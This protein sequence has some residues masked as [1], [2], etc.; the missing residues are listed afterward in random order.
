MRI[1]RRVALIVLLL[2]T[3]F[4]PIACET[5]SIPDKDPADLLPTVVT[6]NY[7]LRFF[8]ERLAGERVAIEWLVPDGVN[9][10]DWQPTAED[11]AKMN[12]ADL[13]LLN[14]AGYEGWLE[15]AS[16]SPGKLVDTSAG[17]KDR[18][19]E[20]DGR[21]HSHGP[22]GSH[23]HA[24][25][26]THTWL[27]PDLALLQ[28]K[29]VLN[30]LAELDPASQDAMQSNY[31]LLQ[32]DLLIRSAG[33]EQA[34]N[35]LPETAVVF[36]HPVYQY[37]QRRFRMNGRSV[38]FEPDQEPDLASV[39]ELDA[40]LAAHPSAWFIWEG[41]PI[42]ENEKLIRNEGLR[43]LVFE[44]GGRPPRTGDL[45]DVL[46]AGIETLRVVYDVPSDS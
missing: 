30:A 8:V 23:S 44:P 9:P 28:A 40:L 31:G 22:D 11:V 5:D 42:P 18:L 17:F 7:P 29:A 46:D 37:L 32:R 12:A 34:I 15:T 1:D 35:T 38:H 43:G 36:S 2:P 16:L 45:L 20:T 33:M 26:A 27:D 13:V 24:G 21:V 41:P 6:T 39:N 10:A 14:G 3:L 25:T 19:I 4:A